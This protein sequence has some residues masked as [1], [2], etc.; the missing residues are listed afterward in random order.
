MTFK[1][2]TDGKPSSVV[3]TAN[4]LRKL[5]KSIDPEIEENIYGAKIK[6]VLYSIGSANNVLYGLQLSDNYCI[7][8]L[9]K[10]DKIDIGDF[11]LEGKGKQAKHIK[12]ESLTAEDSKEL[13]RIF[14]DILKLSK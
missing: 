6:T 2:A 9:H 7:L 8:F 11:K 13:E 10:T 12:F 4:A 3:K 5:I 14:N 1:D